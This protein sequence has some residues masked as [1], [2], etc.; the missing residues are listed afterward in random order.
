LTEEGG[1]AVRPGTAGGTARKRR[2]PCE[3]WRGTANFQVLGAEFFSHSQPSTPQLS[4][5]C[6]FT[7][8]YGSLRVTLRVAFQ[9]SP[10]LLGPYGF[11]GQP[12]GTP[13]PPPAP[14]TLS[15]TLSLQLHPPLGLRSQFLLCCLR[16]KISPFFFR[17]FSVFRG[18]EFR[19]NLCLSVFAPDHRVIASSARL[20]PHDSVRPMILSFLPVPVAPLHPPRLCVNFGRWT[21]DLGLWTLASNHTDLR[22]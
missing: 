20:D 8:T 22:I 12:G 3:H 10:V 6:G 7:S 18:Q 15:R 16:V 13:P 5:L 19:A 14:V 2:K 1:T 17:V 9:K 11:T 4:T 21:L